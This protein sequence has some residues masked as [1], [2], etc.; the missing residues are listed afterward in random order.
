M[1]SILGV[2]I[3]LLPWLMPAADT[4]PGTQPLTLTG[5][6][7]AQMVAGIDRFLDRELEASLTTRAAFW[8][9]DF[10]SDGAYEK[11]IAPNRERLRQF[12]G[13]VDARVPVTQIEFTGGNRTPSLVAETDRY[14]VRTMWKTQPSLLKCAAFCGCLC[15]SIMFERE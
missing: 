10:T 7:S 8:K 14:V 5:D 15:R 11:S 4:L 2:A 6:L 9:R 1:K 3:L 12:I 13:A